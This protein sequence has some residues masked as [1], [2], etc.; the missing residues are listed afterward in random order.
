[1]DVVAVLLVGSVFTMVL[2][3]SPQRPGAGP[4]P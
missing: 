2:K 3:A 1:M 4:P